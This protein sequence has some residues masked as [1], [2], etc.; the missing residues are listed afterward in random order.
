MRARR[1]RPATARSPGSRS[2][3]RG[4]YRARREAPQ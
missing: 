1:S 3:R 2:P 4:P